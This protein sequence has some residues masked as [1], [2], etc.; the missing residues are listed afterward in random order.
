MS[1]PRQLTRAPRLIAAA[2]AVS[3]IALCS[4]LAAAAASWTDSKAPR[5]SWTDAHSPRA[6]WTDSNAPRVSW[7]DSIAAHAKQSAHRAAAPRA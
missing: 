7:N 2:A 5:A 4:P 3:S 6:S 1:L